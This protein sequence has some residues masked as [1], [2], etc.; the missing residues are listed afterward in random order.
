MILNS[1][2]M[3][4]DLNSDLVEKI[5]GNTK[6]VQELLS[7]SLSFSLDSLEKDPEALVKFLDATSHLR[8]LSLLDIDRSSSEAFCLFTNLYHCLLQHALLLAVSG[9]LH[10]R[11]VR[12]FM[13]TSC[14]EVGGDVFSLAEIHCCIIRGNMPPPVASKSPYYVDVAKK[15]NSYLRYALD[16]KEPTVNFIL[17]SPRIVYHLYVCSLPH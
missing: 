13:R 11:T 1:R 9:P 17:V 12:Q 5:G 3:V 8:S 2:R 15:A 10:R 16:F 6:Y 7:T 4:F 14:Y